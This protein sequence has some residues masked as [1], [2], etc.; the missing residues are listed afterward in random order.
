MLVRASGSIH[1]DLF[2]LTL[3]YSCHYLIRSGE[4]FSIFDPGLSAHIPYLIQRIDKLGISLGKLDYIFLTHLHPDR[5]GGLPYMRKVAPSLKVAASPLMRTK[6][7]S[8]EFVRALYDKDLLLSEIIKLPGPTE[9]LDFK[10]YRDL[11]SIDKI[12]VDA[13]LFRFSE[14]LNMRVVSFPGHTSES[15]AYFI[16]P[17]HYLIGDEGLGYYSGRK[18]AAPGGDQSLPD[19]LTSIAKFNDLELAG[20]CFPNTGVVTGSLVRKHLQAIVQNTEDMLTESSNAYMSR[21]PDSDIKFSIKDA[22]FTTDINDPLLANNLEQ[23]YMAIWD[24]VLRE[25][26]KQ[27]KTPL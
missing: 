2:L 1:P 16:Q 20:I 10:E 21:T 22:F 9:K 3:G 27:A 24:Q 17:Y 15:L 7:Q 25:R 5:I 12:I 23:S 6:L 18:F 14:D 13:D 19:M 11:L 8:E 26:E 4:R